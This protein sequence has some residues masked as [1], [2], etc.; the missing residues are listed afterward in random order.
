M[1]MRPDDLAIFGGSVSFDKSLH[2]NRPNAGNKP[3]FQAK[4]DAAWD[5]KWFTNDGPNA[6]ELED[7]LKDYLGVRHCIL[8]SNGTSRWR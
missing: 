3:L 4:L 7:R 8:T 1:K 2:V 5:A 6:Q